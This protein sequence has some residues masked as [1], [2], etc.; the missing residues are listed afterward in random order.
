MTVILGFF[1]LILTTTTGFL[2]QGTNSFLQL[3]SVLKM[4]KFNDL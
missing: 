4:F 1:M 2:E 3:E